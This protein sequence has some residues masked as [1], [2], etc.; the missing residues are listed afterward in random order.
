MSLSLQYLDGKKD[1]KLS[2]PWKKTLSTQLKNL[3]S[4][5]K[6]VK[7]KSSYK[8][9][10]AFKK[11]PPKKK[12]CLQLQLPAVSDV[13]RCTSIEC[14]RPCCCSAVLVLRFKC[15]REHVGASVPRLQQFVCQQSV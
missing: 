3:S 11:G 14:C 6:L 10:D 2:G 7:V 15:M 9:S 5:G 8:L 4:Q 1:W 12:V 13:C